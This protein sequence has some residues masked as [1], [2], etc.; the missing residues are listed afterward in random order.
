MP[1]MPLFVVMNA[2]SGHGDAEAAIATIRERLQRDGRTHELLLAQTPAQLPSLATRAAELARTHDGAVVGAGGDGTLNAVARAAHAAGR[3]FGVLPQ[4]TFNYFA[5][6]HGIPEDT[7]EALDVALR[8]T[9]RPTQVG[10]VNGHLFLVN[11]SLGLYPK[12]LEDREA[13]KK[14]LGRSRAVALGASLMTLLRDHRALTLRLERD[15]QVATL[16]TS[17]VFVG[18]NRLQLERVGVEES[19]DVEGQL[20]VVA[21]KPAN[22]AAMLRL[23]VRGAFGTLGASDDVETFACSRLVVRPRAMFIRRRVA[24]AIDGEIIRQTMPLTFVVASTPLQLLVDP[25]KTRTPA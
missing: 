2:G 17:T 12:L 5:R 4:G 15:D 25:T 9:P 21:V 8:A 23:F 16:R 18:N 11:A 7:A 22:R 10:E 14:R 13:Y 1:G 20:A 3:P 19:D 6:T 24:V